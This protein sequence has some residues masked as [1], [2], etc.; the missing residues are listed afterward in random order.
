[1]PSVNIHR[2]WGDETGCWLIVAQRCRKVE[3]GRGSWRGE[4]W[5]RGRL[6][7]P[8]GSFRGWLCVSLSSAPLL[9]L[10]SPLP[11]FSCYCPKTGSQAVPGKL[12]RQKPPLHQK[13]FELSE[14]SFSPSC[15]TPFLCLSTIRYTTGGAGGRGQTCLFCHSFKY[16]FFSIVVNFIFEIYPVFFDTLHSKKGDSGLEVSLCNFV[17]ALNKVETARLRSRQANCLW[18]KHDLAWTS[19]LL[20]VHTVAAGVHIAHRGCDI[21]KRHRQTWPVLCRM[22]EFKT[23]YNFF[24]NE[25][26]GKLLYNVIIMTKL[27]NYCHHCSQSKHEQLTVI[28]YGGDTFCNALDVPCVGLRCRNWVLYP[29]LCFLECIIILQKARMDKPNTGST[30]GLKNVFFYI[31]SV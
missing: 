29:Y 2:G 4:E 31:F 16:F 28:L 6:T 14:P 30:E 7:F 17:E 27:C 3:G 1:M 15:L 11:F 22:L 20:W 12:L 13:A 19:C 21:A 5:L 10:C 9:P 25:A 26:C 8:E 24:F 23:H 18:L